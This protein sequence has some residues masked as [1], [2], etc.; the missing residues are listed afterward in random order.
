MSGAAPL[1]LLM[2][3][4][5]VGGVWQYALDLAA[6]LG[7]HGVQTTL[8]VLGPS[9][10]P[11]QRAEAKR[12]KRLTLVDTRLPLDWLCDAPEP[13]LAAGEAI[14]ALAGKLGADIVQ[15]NMPTLG[16]RAKFDVPVLA[17]THGCVATWWSAAF[18][19]DLAPQYRW[20]RL[21]MDEGLHA[22]DLVVAPSAAYAATVARHYA[23]AETPRAI[24]NGRPPLL[25][26]PGPA[27]PQEDFALT[28]GR[29][30]DRVKGI[31]TLDRAAAAL[32]VSFHA[33]GAVR[34]PHG[35]TIALEH[36]HALGHLS[37]AA[38]A[39]RLAARPVFVSAAGFEPFGLAV[40]EAAHAGCPLVLSDIDTFRELW[41]DA[42]LFVAPDDA[43]GYAAG[44]ETILADP[45]LRHRLGSAARSRAARYT[46][47]AKAAAMATLFTDLAAKA[48]AKRAA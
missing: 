32:S 5:A 12:V 44:V 30:W 41:D 46:P 27:M 9:P 48:P 17:V 40:L 35:E 20:H 33:A 29:L 36:L 25:P 14:A 26:A 24:H 7:P 6:A 22:A 42:A 19:G 10:S 13:V 18:G 11:A 43:A 16:A 3:A 45:A 47:E 4:D 28:A 21:L 39:L 38:L 8:A 2:T 1:K 15:L 37:S 23:L 34:G 31:R